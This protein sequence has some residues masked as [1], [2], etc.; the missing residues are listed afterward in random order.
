M[1]LGKNLSLAPSQVQ[2][3][4]YIDGAEMI[5]RSFC[6][7]TVDAVEK[8]GTALWDGGAIALPGTP[9]LGA[10]PFFAVSW[11]IWN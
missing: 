1:P 4:A 10:F 5:P 9:W 6:C 7:Q 8:V 2:V 3:Q 11:E